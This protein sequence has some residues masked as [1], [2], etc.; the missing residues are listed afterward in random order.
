MSIYSW[1]NPR[2]TRVTRLVILVELGFHCLHIR[3]PL[4]PLHKT[5]SFPLPLTACHI[6]ALHQP[7]GKG[8]YAFNIVLPSLV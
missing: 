7:H 6:N 5:M 8:P 4:P 2:L 3:F 1:S